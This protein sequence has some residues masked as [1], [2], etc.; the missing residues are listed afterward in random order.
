MTKFTDLLESIFLNYIQ[1]KYSLSSHYMTTV[2]K[3]WER[4]GLKYE[5]YLWAALETKI[6]ANNRAFIEDSNILFFSTW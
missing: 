3:I 6:L 4:K 2:I 5:R 1:T